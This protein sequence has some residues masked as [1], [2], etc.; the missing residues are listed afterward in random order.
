MGLDGKIVLFHLDNRQTTLPPG[1]V[2]KLVR[3]E[4]I[5]LFAGRKN[6]LTLVITDMHMPVMDGE[7]TIRTLREIKPAQKIIGTSDVQRDRS[8]TE[9]SRQHLDA[10]LT[11]PFTTQ[12]LPKI[13]LGSTG[14]SDHDPH[15]EHTSSAAATA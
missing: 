7:T 5:A 2:K 9:P 13:V 10:Y 8:L 15:V 1:C 6:A 3:A 14:L 12:D 4:A 11:K